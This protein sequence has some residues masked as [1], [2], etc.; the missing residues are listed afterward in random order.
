M[1]ESERD[2]RSYLRDLRA[3]EEQERKKAE[4]LLAAS[5]GPAKV[6]AVAG[7]VAAE[8]EAAASV[9]SSQREQRRMDI[10][11][12][13]FQKRQ[14]GLER[15]RMERE[16]AYSREENMKFREELQELKDKKMKAKGSMAR[17]AAAMRAEM[18]GLS[19]GFSVSALTAS[20]ASFALVIPTAH[21]L[22]ARRKGPAAGSA[23]YASSEESDL[24]P[25]D[26]SFAEALGLS[27]KDLD[28]GADAE[29]ENEDEGSCKGGS[30]VSAITHANLTDPVG[31]GGEEEPP[32][33]RGEP[34]ED[35]GG[36]PEVA[37][38]EPEPDEGL[39]KEA[40]AKAEEE[41]REPPTPVRAAPTAKR[42]RQLLR[43]HD[44]ESS[45][46]ST[47]Y[48]SDDSVTR[49]TKES[50]LSSQKKGNCVTSLLAGAGFDDDDSDEEQ[51]AI[52]A[53]EEEAEQQMRRRLKRAKMRHIKRLRR[54]AELKD[55]EEAEIASQLEQ[56]HQVCQLEG[57]KAKLSLLRAQELTSML[58]KELKMEL[59]NFRVIDLCCQKQSMVEGQRHGEALMLW[60]RATQCKA[61]YHACLKW[62]E[63]CTANEHR[64]LKWKE[65][66]MRET[67]F[68]HGKACA[69]TWQRWKTDWAQ[70]ELHA[71]Y[72][73]SLASIIVN[74][75]ELI[76]TERSMM[77]VHDK[78]RTNQDEILHREDLVAKLWRKHRRKQLMCLRRSELGKKI[79]SKCQRH[80]LERVMEAWMRFHLWQ[81]GLREAFTLR[82][83]VIKQEM[84]L[85]QLNRQAEPRE[86]APET[87]LQRS[88][89]GALTLP[90]HSFR[91]KERAI[92]CR[93][94]N[95]KYLESQNHDLAC[96]YHS[97]KYVMACPRSCT[98]LGPQCMSH[99][100]RRWTCCD[101]KDPGSWGSSG[102][103]RRH[104]MPPLEGSPALRE[105]VSRLDQKA[106]EKL[107]HLDE[108][109]AELAH[110]DNSA[111]VKES[112]ALLRAM[113]ENRAKEIQVVE[114]YKETRW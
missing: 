14:E 98:G 92:T 49:R 54:L 9:I 106:K 40:E 100:I 24:C 58:E 41:A 12:I 57:A 68:F 74:R 3:Y 62:E 99:R 97:G 87:L 94:C 42:G 22:G 50:K 64:T 95:Q 85:K 44:A 69:G 111:S 8:E 81:Q 46:A 47:A 7:G 61:T 105:K 101:E 36:P 11:L 103:L 67:A 13:K 86:D 70:P 82:F 2:M 89:G 71:L 96:S 27:V 102:C 84:Q 30:V 52:K 91:F 79:F 34:S 19:S 60:E 5:A 108:R 21:S 1:A 112:Q 83:E 39:E 53:R 104:H 51:R 37:E 77:T 66:V 76:V 73:R 45:E 28:I 114:R 18:G 32:T 43:Y 109:L 110:V 113:Q 48:S 88:S 107:C 6:R 20:D 16:D 90:S 31:H 29:N 17:M 38:G 72:F 25:E 55:A 65:R 80:T 35:V 26:F 78:L 23:E 63:T 4:A 10:K 56:K 59:E 33:S 15:E 93:L 75:A